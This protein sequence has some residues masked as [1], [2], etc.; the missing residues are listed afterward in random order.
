MEQTYTKPTRVRVNP[1]R[2]KCEMIIMRILSTEIRENGKNT[3]F[4]NAMDFMAYFESLYPAGS[5]LTKQ[6]QRA[7]KSMDLA[8]DEK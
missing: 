5:A 7:I 8:K 3:H 1:S 2:A 6:V 4:K